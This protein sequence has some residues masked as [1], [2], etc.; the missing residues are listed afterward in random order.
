M[1]VAM[2]RILV[3]LSAE[4]DG[5]PLRLPNAGEVEFL[6]QLKTSEDMLD[7]LVCCCVRARFLEGAANVY[8]DENSGI[9][10]PTVK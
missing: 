10:V 9:W 1:L 8:G 7:D 5:I 4:I 2:Q 3:G 6:T